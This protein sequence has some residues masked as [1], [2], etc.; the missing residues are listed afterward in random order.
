MTRN[1]AE[2]TIRDY[3]SLLGRAVELLNSKGPP[4]GYISYP[5]WARLYFDGD[6]AV[7]RD[8]DV[9][10]YYD[11]IDIDSDSS[12]FPASLLFMT[13]D[14]LK[15]WKRE[16]SAAEESAEAERKR[17]MIKDAEEKE[18]AQLASL[19]AKYGE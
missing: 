9:S 16:T 3:E 17:K 12:R 7:V 1:E 14:E 2:K 5:E 18:R 13:N 11:S 15:E 4:Y 19:K 6:A 8:L 10:T